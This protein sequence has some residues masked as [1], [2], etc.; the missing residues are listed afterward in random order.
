[1]NLSLLKNRLFLITT[2]I[3]TLLAV[4]Y[5]GLFAVDVYISVDQVIAAV[6]QEPWLAPKRAGILQRAVNWIRFGKE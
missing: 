1:M 2:A 5:F 3:P 6:T 4:L